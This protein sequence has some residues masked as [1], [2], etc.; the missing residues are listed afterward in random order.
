MKED[1]LYRGIEI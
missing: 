1:Y